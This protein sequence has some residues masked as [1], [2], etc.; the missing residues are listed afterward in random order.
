MTNHIPNAYAFKK[1]FSCPQKSNPFSFLAYLTIDYLFAQLNLIVYENIVLNLFHSWQICRARNFWVFSSR[2]LPLKPSLKSHQITIFLAQKEG[3]VKTSTLEWKLFIL[4]KQSCHFMIPFLMTS[5]ERE[6]K[7]TTNSAPESLSLSAK[8][9][10]FLKNW[11]HLP[12]KTIK[13]LRIN[14]FCQHVNMITI[15]SFGA[16]NLLFFNKKNEQIAVIIRSELKE[17]E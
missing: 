1:F 12:R 7:G 9:I 6:K 11:K 2:S 5:S 4:N 8:N 16:C 15:F 3:W 14:L 13:L 17:S 10:V